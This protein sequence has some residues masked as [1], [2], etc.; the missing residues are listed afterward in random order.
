[1]APLDREW[2]PPLRAEVLIPADLNVC[3]LVTTIRQSSRKLRAGVTSFL[4]SG[5]PPWA[6]HLGTPRPTRRQCKPF[7]IF[8]GLSGHCLYRSF[9]CL[10]PLIRNGPTR[11]L[12]FGDEVFSCI[13]SIFALVSFF[14]ETPCRRWVVAAPACIVFFCVLGEIVA[15]EM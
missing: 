13:F 3:M 6:P 12:H 10:F 14:C 1:M 4:S 7:S 11:P 9:S 8:T 2:H 5:F 15:F